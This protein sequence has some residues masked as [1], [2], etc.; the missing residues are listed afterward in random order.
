M[1]DVDYREL[2][3]D[4]PLPTLVVRD[5]AVLWANGA[6]RLVVGAGPDGPAPVGWALTALV[7]PD[8]H[9]ALATG[10]AVGARTGPA[11]PAPPVEW[12]FLAAG[13][14]VTTVEVRIA[15]VRFEGA[16]ALA[17]LCWDVSQ[18]VERQRD[19]AHRATHDRLTGL[20]NRS[21]FEDRWSQAR[22]RARRTGRV[23]V[24]AFCDVDD[25]K[26]FNDRY[27]HLAG[28]AVLVA[29]A[30]RL[31]AAAREE[32]T[33]ARYGGDEFVVL[34]EGPAE[35]EPAALEERFR[36]AVT[37]VA[38]ELPGVDGGTSLT[39]SV[40]LVV[41]DPVVPPAEVLARADARMYRDKRTRRP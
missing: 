14:A 22:S 7:H 1:Q 4:S 2:V 21:L 8:D 23:P 29:V 19:L 31:A 36:R 40:G 26:R 32:D 25:L 6:A 28:D 35:V 27:G 24:V 34:V 3:E 39:C 5:G 38:V 33:V 12:R 20:P 37:D 41:D 16:P 11:Q 18:H 13:G 15:P 9:D 17:L 10:L 30:R